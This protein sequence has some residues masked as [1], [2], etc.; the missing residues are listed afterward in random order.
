MN[1]VSG[2]LIKTLK[3]QS[4]GHKLVAN[5]GE[6]SVHDAELKLEKLTDLNSNN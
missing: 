4:S 5:S 3:K 2:V 6:E 1:L